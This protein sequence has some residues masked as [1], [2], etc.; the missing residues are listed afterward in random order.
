MSNGYADKN[1]LIYKH[2][3]AIVIF[4]WYLSNSIIGFHDSRERSEST[5]RHLESMEA[6]HIGGICLKYRPIVN[7]ELK[8]V[9]EESPKI[10]LRDLELARSQPRLPVEKSP[11]VLTTTRFI[12]RSDSDL[13]VKIYE[14]INK[15]QTK[16]PGLL[17]IHGGGYIL[18][19]P[20]SDDV[21]CETFVLDVNCKVVSVDYRLAPEDPYPAAIEDCYDALKWMADNAEELNIDRSRIAIAGA[22]AGGGLTAALALLARDR[23]GPEIAFQMPL[24][25]M[26]DDRN[27]TKSS[28]QINKDNFPTVWHREVN[29]RAWKMYLGNN[30]SDD[31]PYYAAPARATDLSGLP[32]TYTCVGELDPFRDETLEY[33]A[34]LAQAGVPVEFH[35]Y[36]GCFHGFDL[37]PAKPEIGVRA[38][39]EYI[40][41]LARALHP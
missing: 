3:H 19:H 32:P 18:G 14:P 21:L 5:G 28:N 1:L 34:R 24:Y 40:S 13:M 39:K 36:P 2:I 29:Q 11:F 37:S 33:V 17:W 26:I 15:P 41:A 23:G 4:I 8:Q 35:L 22:S 25:P 12:K 10:E 38:Q 6:N 16:L 9:L 27:I 7:P 30:A 31:I 20:D